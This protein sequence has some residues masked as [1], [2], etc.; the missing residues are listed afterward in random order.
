M[1]IIKIINFKRN[2]YKEKEMKVAVRREQQPVDHPLS[3]SKPT[4][5]QKG[6]AQRFTM[7]VT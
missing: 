1:I 3:D 6:L 2:L 4:A 5:L 7:W